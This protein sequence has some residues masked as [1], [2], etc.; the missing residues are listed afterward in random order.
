MIINCRNE[1]GQSEIA[2]QAL[3]W[4]SL[5]DQIA[6]N[7]AG[8]ANIL[9]IILNFIYSFYTSYFFTFQLDNGVT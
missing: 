4:I 7:K 5:A 3:G 2:M 1:T 6:K 9:C 8:P